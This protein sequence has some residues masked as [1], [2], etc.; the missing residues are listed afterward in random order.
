M[1]PHSA[2]G[3]HIGVSLEHYRCYR[4]WI[5]EMRSER[6]RNTV[7]FKHNYL[8]MPTITNAD[9]VLIAAKDLQT[10]LKGGI[11]QALQT[12]AAV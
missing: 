3:Y 9:A 4:I 5:K 6:I 10:A 2:T 7:I 8:T 1:A 11:P 12:T